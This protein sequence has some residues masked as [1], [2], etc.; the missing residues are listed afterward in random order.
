MEK[1]V[2]NRKVDGEPRDCRICPML[3]QR[4]V[5]K[6]REILVLTENKSERLKE[7]TVEG[8]CKLDNTYSLL[9]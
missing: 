6:W 9:C 1:E 3:K 2:R 7:F 5:E 4:G 8:S